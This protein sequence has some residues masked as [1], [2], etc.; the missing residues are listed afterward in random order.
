MLKKGILRFEVPMPVGVATDGNHPLLQEAPVLPEQFFWQEKLDKPEK[1]LMEAVLDDALACWQRGKNKAHA[2]RLKK[3]AEEWFFS[4]ECQ[5]PF[6]FLYICD[7]LGFDGGNIRELIKSDTWHYTEVRG[8]AARKSSR[9]FVGHPTDAQHVGRRLGKQKSSKAA[10]ALPIERVV[11]ALR[12]IKKRAWQERYTPVFAFF[13]FHL[14]VPLQKVSQIACY[15]CCSQTY[16]HD[17]LRK[18][19]SR[20]I[21]NGEQWFFDA[22]A[23][24]ANQCGM[25]KN[26]QQALCVLLAKAK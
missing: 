8:S 14:V 24:V 16:A 11:H 12:V 1:K 6:S 7:V 21:R 9:S 15:L 2:R 18:E 19:F 13:F 23:E 22:L 26:A 25:D 5:W 17:R 20:A 3:E 10:I 4:E